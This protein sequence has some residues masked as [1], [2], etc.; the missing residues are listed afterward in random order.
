M[1]NAS[2]LTETVMW[3]S[4]TVG[5]LCALIG[6]VVTLLDIARNRG[7]GKT[8]AAA[9]AKAEEKVSTGSTAS[10]DLAAQ[11]AIG[12]TMESLAKL[13]SSLKDLDIGT[14]VLM[15]A[16]AFYAIAG[17]AAGL[18]AIGMGLGTSS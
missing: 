18:D 16:L 3:F 1:D 15:V 5:S 13:A 9:V 6:L 10:E 12:D 2:D 11:G 17:V 7:V 14:R 4:L 8:A